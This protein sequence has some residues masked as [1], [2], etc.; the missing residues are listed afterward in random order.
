MTTPTAGAAIQPPISRSLATA[1]SH[2]YTN[3]ANNA[4]H[5][6]NKSFTF[7]VTITTTSSPTFGGRRFA[8]AA[9]RSTNEE[10]NSKSDDSEPPFTSQ[11]DDVNFL[12]KLGAGSFAGAAA[13]KYGSI[14]L[15]EI[16]RPNIIQAL[17][18][19]ST[20]V[21]VSVLILIKQSSVKQ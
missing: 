13:I 20:P 8:V 3:V 11:D 19:I 2:Q 18:M 7:P 14:I 12:L 5:I 15:P 17:V 16:T 6:R 9:S 4:I 10:A 21:I 1:I